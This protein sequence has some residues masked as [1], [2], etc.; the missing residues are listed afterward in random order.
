[1]GWGLGAR[2]ESRAHPCRACAQ[3]EDCRETS[4]IRDPAGGNDRRPRRGVDD[5]GHERER[6]HAAP[7]V[8]AR[9]PALGDEDVDPG[10][11]GATRLLRA[12]D[13]QR[14]QRAGAVDPVDEGRG[15]PPGEGQEGSACVERDLDALVLRRILRI[16]D[17]VDPER[18]VRALP[19]CAD[20]VPN[21]VRLQPGDG[22]HAEAAGLGH[23]RCERRH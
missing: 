21:L 14:C 7:D 13:G 9:L 10:V 18:A 19:E 1:M 12:P 16:D 23:R 20:R 8:A 2:D 17:H 22:H 15:V 5:R 11:D 6:G 3:G 4:P